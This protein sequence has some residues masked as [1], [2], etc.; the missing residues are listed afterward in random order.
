MVPHSFKGFGRTEIVFL[1]I[2]VSP[3]FLYLY[4]SIREANVQTVKIGGGRACVKTA[5]EN[6]AFKSGETSLNNS[7]V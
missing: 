3:Q 1:S 4:T 2:Y 7:F 6:H 5:L